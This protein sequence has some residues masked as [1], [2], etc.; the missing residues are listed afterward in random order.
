MRIL[1]VRPG[2]QADHSSS[3]YLFY[4]VDQPV[5]AAGQRI[6]HRFSSRAD[7]DEQYARYQKWGDYEL[8]SE[9]YRALLGEHYDVMASESYDSWTLMIAVPKTPQMQQLL[10]PFHDLDDGEFVRLDVHDYRKR[11]AIEIFC[12]FDYDGPLWSRTETTSRNWSKL[13]AEIRAK[14]CAATSRSFRRWRTSTRPVRKRT[15]TR[16]LRPR[17]RP[18]SRPRNG[19]RP[20]CR[21]SVPGAAS[22]SRNPGPRVNCAGAGVRRPRP[23][24]PVPASAA[25]VASRRSCP[26]PPGRSSIAWPPMNTATACHVQISPA[27]RLRR[28][29]WGGVAFDRAGGDL[30]EVDAEGFAVL[31]ALRTA[32]ALPAL[33]RRLSPGRPARGPELA[34]F[35]RGLERRGFVRRVGP[36]APPLPADR[37]TEE[38]PG[39]ADGLRAPL[40][41]HGR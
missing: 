30:L 6:A 3:S 19:A 20:D 37:W 25:A 35:L 13:L 9:A 40:V 2:L 5:G 4:A 10:R 36:A 34:A 12:E 1:R 41:A 17:R 32:H 8:S 27:V 26:A 14:S 16:T 24:V 39:A 7:V 18:G 23:R 33:Q 38:A 28:E 22:R 11:L 31:A 21:R 29:A 15:R